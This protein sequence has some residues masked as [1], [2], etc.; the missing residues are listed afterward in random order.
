MIIQFADPGEPTADLASEL[1]KFC[2]DIL[3]QHFDCLGESIE[4]A[5]EI[6]ESIDP[7]TLKLIDGIDLEAPDAGLQLLSQALA[8]KQPIE[9]WWD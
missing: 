8:L 5:E 2:P 1:A 9:L 7:S 6:G 3:S 4:I